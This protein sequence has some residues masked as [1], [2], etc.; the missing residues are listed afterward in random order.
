MNKWLKEANTQYP[1][2]DISMAENTTKI[3]MGFCIWHILCDND[4]TFN[5]Q[6]KPKGRFTDPNLGFT[7]CIIAI[8][9][10]RNKKPITTCLSG[11]F[12]WFV[13]SLASRITSLVRQ[14]VKFRFEINNNIKNKIEEKTKRPSVF[15]V[16][17]K[18][19]EGLWILQW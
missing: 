18:R 6:I 3:K 2:Y 10:T 5:I 19:K 17:S 14:W 1:I 9:R 4:K 8:I 15:V 12:D 11:P 16:L 7:D 13:V